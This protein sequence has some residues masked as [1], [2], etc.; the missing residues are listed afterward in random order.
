MASTTALYNGLSGLS[1][2]ATSLDVTG[3]NI[4]NVNTTAFKSSRTLF[5][6]Q[7]SRTISGGSPP[8]DTLGGTNPFQVGLGVRVSGTQRDF[9]AGSIATTGDPRDLAIDGEGFFIVR[10]GNDQLF[11]RNGAFRTNARDELVTSTGENVQ[12][13]GVDEA[14]NVTG[15]LT[16]IEIPVGSMTLAEETQNVEFAGNLNADGDLPTTGTRITFAPFLT[17]AG[18]ADAGTTL[19]SI[20]DPDVVGMSLFSAGQTF[21]FTSVEKG[22]RTLPEASLTITEATTVGDLAQFLSDSLAIETTVGPNP[23]GRTP[24]VTIDPATGVLTIDGNTGVVNNVLIDASDLRLTAADGTLLSQPLTP[25]LV[26]ESDGESVRTQFIVYDS[27]GTPLQVDLTF[28]L[29]TVSDQGTTWRYFAESHDDS[30]PSSGVGT[31]TVGFDPFGQLTAGAIATVAIDR[32][33][34]GAADPLSVDFRFDTGANGLTAFSDDDSSM[35][36]VLQDG[37]PLGTL[38]AFEVGIDGVITGAFT[39]GLTRT[40]GQVSLATF[41]NNEGLLDDGGGFFRP[42]ANSGSALVQTPRQLGSGGIL[43]GTLEQSNVDLS[44]EFID[45]ILA[46]TGYSASSRVITTTDQ[47]FQQLLVLGR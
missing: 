10:R 35:A 21:Q 22:N 25:T 18:F 26:N 33:N 8:N 6:S 5:S 24:G 37:A 3:N 36:A 4:A 45:L 16:D 12:G 13:Y 9:A 34:T 27:L 20:N 44:Q 43:A 30:V 32:D 28:V 23:D 47:L 39:N 15:T 1:A 42:G 31:G 14:F 29:D 38:A 17:D 11:T 2:H 46:S 7:L 41:A 40:L 19:T